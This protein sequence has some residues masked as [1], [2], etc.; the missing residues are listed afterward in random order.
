MSNPLCPESPSRWI[1]KRFKHRIHI[2]PQSI[3]T[4]PQADTWLI[5]AGLLTLRS[6]NLSGYFIVSDII[7]GEF[8]RFPS[9]FNASNVDVASF[10]V[11]KTAL[12]EFERDVGVRQY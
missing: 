10:V 9:I 6:I 11:G 8:D 5:H 1:P 2:T 12:V 4:K 3:S 7:V